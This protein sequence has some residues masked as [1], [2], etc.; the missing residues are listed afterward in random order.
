[1]R[2]GG[3]DANGQLSGNRAVGGAKGAFSLGDEG[4]EF[5]GVMQ[6]DRALACEGDAAG[7]AIEEASAKIV[8]QGLYLQGDRGLGNKEMLGGF[9]KIKMRGDGA[10][11]L[12]AEIL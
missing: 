5:I 11:D 10:K 4:G 3:G 9:A 12:Q 6:K 1:L 2:D 8:F 7:S